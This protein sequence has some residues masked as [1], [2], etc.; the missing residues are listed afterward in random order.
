M[1]S[2]L[3]NTRDILLSIYINS[4]SKT[5]LLNKNWFSIYIFTIF[6]IKWSRIIDSNLINSLNLFPL[7][8]SGSEFSFTWNQMFSTQNISP[9][10]WHSL[11]WGLSISS[12]D[13]SNDCLNVFLLS[14]IQPFL[15]STKAA[16]LFKAQLFFSYVLSRK[17]SIWPYFL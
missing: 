11:G 3:P 6:R 12:L 7:S 5:G 8:L 13:A 9:S 14:F 15:D 16:F 17:S 1:F 2:S 10:Y 4:L